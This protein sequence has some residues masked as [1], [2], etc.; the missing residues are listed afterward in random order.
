M[1]S[2]H[3]FFSL[4]K[5]PQ[6]EER[7]AN[8]EETKTETGNSFKSDDDFILLPGRQKVMQIQMQISNQQLMTNL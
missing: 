1:V 5:P 7:Q 4:S 6:K 3:F 2:S 8:K